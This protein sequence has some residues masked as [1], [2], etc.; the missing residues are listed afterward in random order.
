VPGRAAKIDD[1][2]TRRKGRFD[3]VQDRGA[4]PAI[5]EVGATAVP[6]EF[7]QILR[8]IDRS[9]GRHAGKV[10][11][12]CLTVSKHPP[13]VVADDIRAATYPNALDELSL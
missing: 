3:F 10:G 2:M 13:V 7:L 6:M 9:I 12:T 11:R 4:S 5:E 1:D 8:P